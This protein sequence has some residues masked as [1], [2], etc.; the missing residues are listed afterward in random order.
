MLASECSDGP[1]PSPIPMPTYPPL[2]DDMCIGKLDGEKF[3]ENNKTLAVCQ[4]NVFMSKVVCGDGLIC[5]GPK[6]K[7]TQTFDCPGYPPKPVPPDV[8]VAKSECQ[9]FIRGTRTCSADSKQSLI[10]DGLNGE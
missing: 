10:C 2:T 4:A 7:C 3:C 9:G 8:L 5:C 6:R 1:S